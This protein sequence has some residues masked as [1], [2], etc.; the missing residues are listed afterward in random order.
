MCY[1]IRCIYWSPLKSK[2]GH[3]KTHMGFAEEIWHVSRSCIITWEWTWWIALSYNIAGA[4][5]GSGYSYPSWVPDVIS[6]LVF[7]WEFVLL[8]SALII[9][10]VTYNIVSFI[11]LFCVIFFLVHY[12]VL[13]DLLCF[14]CTRVGHFFL[15]LCIS[16][17]PLLTLFC[18]YLNMH[19]TKLGVV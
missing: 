4:V 19:A 14:T 1:I 9:V 11:V 6:V 7:L 15:F 16:I 12:I 13:I 5:S 17:I 10:C 8:D 18:R 2:S 3:C